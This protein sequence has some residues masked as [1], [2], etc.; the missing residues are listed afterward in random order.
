MP[1]FLYCSTVVAFAVGE[2][3]K[4]GNGFLMIGAHTDRCGS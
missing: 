4:P 1:F 3:Y 2:K